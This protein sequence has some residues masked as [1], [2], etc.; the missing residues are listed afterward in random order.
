[1]LRWWRGR[2]RNEAEA[3]RG[4]AEH[5]RRRLAWA[6]DWAV[7]QAQRTAGPDRVA[8]VMDADVQREAVDQFALKVSHQAAVTALRE[9]LTLRHDV[10]TDAFDDRPGASNP[11]P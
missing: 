1:M 3:Q 7:R 11:M 10:H 9:R 6:A 8:W 4:G 5:E 2:R